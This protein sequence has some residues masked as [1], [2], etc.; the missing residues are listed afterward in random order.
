MASP[1]DGRWPELPL[2]PWRSTH[3]ALHLWTQIAG[4]TLL[5]SSP[6]Q[7]HYWHATLRVSPRGLRSVPALDA[8]RAFELEFD[9]LEHHLAVRTGD[10]RT[11]ALPLGPGSV[12]DFYFDFERLLAGLGID[13]PIW[14]RPVEIPDPVPFDEDRAP[15][16][17]DRAQARAFFEVLRCCD[18]VLEEFSSGFV[19]KQSPVHFFW[20]AFD[21]A[22][23]RFS[24]R[25]APERPGADR[26]TR[27]AYSHE[28]LSFGFWPGGRLPNG[29]SVDEPIFYAYQ[30]PEAEYLRE[31]AVEPVGATYDAAL[32]EFVLPYARALATGDPA[33]ALR[34]FC[35]SVYAAGAK[36]GGWDRAAL[37]RQPAR[38]GPA[39]GPEAREGTHHV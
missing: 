14:T 11:A 13:V 26:V 35:E 25:R 27:E 10:G 2:A 22:Q 32:G 12:R 36:L 3:D 5:A 4:K 29:A 8:G 34:L 20:G 31:A 15:R 28:V 1:A 17:Y 7:N 18:A 16:A 23:T 21:L 33:G 19:G 6:P 38:T 39:P 24:G 9:F 37:E 30:A